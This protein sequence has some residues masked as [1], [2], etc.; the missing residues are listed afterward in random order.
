MNY[1]KN[2][3]KLIDGLNYKIDILESNNKIIS[4]KKIIPKIDSCSKIDSYRITLNDESNSSNKKKYIGLLFDSNFNNFESDDNSGN[5]NLIPFI[6]LHKSNIIIN[7]NIQLELKHIVLTSV[8]CSIAL[9]IK[10]KSES[11]I[12]IIKGTRQIFDIYNSKIIMG[13]INLS[14]TSIYMAEGNEE[15]F[16][17][18]NLNSVCKI[19]SKKSLI[20]LLYFY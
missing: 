12:K 16:M 7:Y 18:A 1:F 11:K 10:N 17:V 8:I 13:S 15:L 19:N 5:K 3:H 20:K 6:K 9:G 4:N 14:N 2:L